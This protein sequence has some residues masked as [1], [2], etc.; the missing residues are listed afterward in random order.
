MKRYYK[1]FVLAVAALVCA[2]A[3]GGCRGEKARP[4]ITV[5]QT[6][7]VCGTGG[8]VTLPAASATDAKYGDISSSVKVRVI[9]DGETAAAFDNGGAE[10]FFAPADAGVYVAE[11]SVVNKDKAQGD[12][13]TV[14]ISVYDAGNG[15]AVLS[16]PVIDVDALAVTAIG[17]GPVA[18]KTARG[19]GVNGGDLSAAIVAKVIGSDGAE[20]YA[21]A[22]GGV[23][24][25][26]DGT[27]RVV[28][29]LEEGGLRADP[30]GYV[31]TVAGA[32]RKKP[33]LTA[34]SMPET[35]YVGQPLTV[36]TAN[37]YDADEGDLSGRVKF[38][39][40]GGSDNTVR[41][42]TAAA[43][44]Q[45]H[46]FDEAGR[47]RV[48]YAAENSA[49]LPAD[50]R[51]YDVEARPVGTAGE[52]PAVDGLTD[53]EAYLGIPAYR[54][55]LSGT[56]AYRFAPTANGLYIGADVKDGALIRGR[57]ADAKEAR[58]NTGDG[59]DFMFDPAD[60]GKD[61]IN[62]SA[63]CFRIRVGITGADTFEYSTYVS[64]TN[65]Q[66]LAEGGSPR[67]DM[68][69]AAG[70]GGAGCIRVKTYGTVAEN[71]ATP[72]SGADMRDGD[73][74]YAVE[75]YIPWAYFGYGAEPQ[76]AAGYGKNYIR[77]GLGHR[78]ACNTEYRNAFREAGASDLIESANNQYCNG[79]MLN[80]RPKV[81][82]E[83]LAPSLYS[84]LYLSGAGKGVNPC[85]PSPSVVLDGFMEESF[86]GDAVDWP[87]GSTS[88]RSP[89]TAKI[90]LAA[91]GFYGGVYIE[92]RQII[93]RPAQALGDFGIFGNDAID[94]R[95]AVNAEKEM[96]ALPASAAK[97]TD[98]KLI[99]LD[100]C[101]GAYLE[102]LMPVGPGRTLKPQPFAYGTAVDGTVGYSETCGASAAGAAGWSNGRF[103]ADTD[104]GDADKGWG[105]EVFV[106]WATLNV[107]PPMPGATLEIRALITVYDR[108][109]DSTGAAWANSYIKEGSRNSG[110]ATVPR[111][112]FAVSKAF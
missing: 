104:V 85:A 60:S 109:A 86:W 79:M 55:G 91:E 23:S 80:A 48:V 27:Y 81:A 92:D 111:S 47:Y 3:F 11:Y 32:A 21:G 75:L 24:G 67:I 89:V 26:T 37:A 58:L 31:L 50:E 64:Q 22:V 7:L 106:P 82:T 6:A 99:A 110:N 71:N 84:Y 70:G 46:G 90:K 88:S 36:S 45:T 100:P 18:L 9:K 30:K 95:I 56:V 101:G 77:L 19:R 93:G 68:S 53:D 34:P 103:I 44:P 74:G 69:G 17:G 49:G 51:G 61:Y 20:K 10:N 35:V 8:G 72:M 13:K 83:G 87:F 40:V 63:N 14:N 57:G 33:I 112:Y 28:Y 15:A 108:G 62:Q 107:T 66:W 98:S 39:I 65:D 42:W 4:E 43:S 54:F 52:T 73:A 105:V 16:K 38:K 94:M 1:F 2:A 5:E 76:A 29:T 97:F 12:K 96:A 25:L 78:D 102:A 41:D 59:L